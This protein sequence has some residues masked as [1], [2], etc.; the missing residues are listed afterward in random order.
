MSSISIRFP[1]G[2]REFRYPERPLAVGDVLHH[3]GERYR[4]LSVSNN[5]DGRDRAT[6]ELI[7]EDLIDKLQSEEG[8]LRLVPAE[9]SLEG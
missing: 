2:S 9:Q 8:G 3:D 1:D 4:V 6:V 7:S 5:E